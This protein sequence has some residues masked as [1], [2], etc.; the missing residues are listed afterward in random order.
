MENIPNIIGNHFVLKGTFNQ[1]YDSKKWS[2]MLGINA[3][4]TNDVTM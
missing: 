2:R 3:K 4:D 1:C